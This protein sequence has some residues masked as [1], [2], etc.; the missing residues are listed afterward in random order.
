VTSGSCGKQNYCNQFGVDDGGRSDI[1]GMG[2]M[3][4]AFSAC[5]A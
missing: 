4:R 2:Y 3:A 5:I 1:D